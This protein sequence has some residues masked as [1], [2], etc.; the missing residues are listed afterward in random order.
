[1]KLRYIFILV[2][3]LVV[4]SGCKDDD[5]NNELTVSSSSYAVA[6]NQVAVR[7]QINSD[8]P[9]SVSSDA[10]WCVPDRDQGNGSETLTVMLELNTM[11]A[12]RSA[13]LTISNAFSSQKVQ[14]TQSGEEHYKL[15]VIFHVLY[16]DINDPNQYVRK[17]WL[18]KILTLCNQLYANQFEDRNEDKN[19]VDMN[20]EF[21]LA[22]T[23]PNGRTLEEPGANRIF[24]PTSTIDCDIFMNTEDPLHASLLWD[25]N[26][27][28][29]IFLYTFTNPGVAGIAHIP[30]TFSANPL[31]GLYSGDVYYTSQPAYPHCV[32]IN[33]VDIYV[34]EHPNNDVSVTL[35]HELGHYL[36]LFHAFGQ[37]RIKNDQYIDWKDDTDY[38][39]DTPNYDRGAYDQWLDEYFASIPPGESGSFYDVIKRTS[40]TGATFNSTNIMD[41]YYT[42]S[43]EF[44][45]DQRKRVRHVLN[46]SPL[47]PGAKYHR[48][49][50]RNITDMKKP[51]IRAI[52]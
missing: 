49:Q 52:Q 6:Y 20:V 47:I 46:Y 34:L 26:Q 33:N 28:I 24:W 10:V 39:D 19:S 45:P 3:L 37:S 17:D 9:W 31:N 5:S 50:S 32:S 51:P 38:C 12:E 21:I 44:T 35:A 8:L 40:I 29:N 7:I 1:M 4:I 2:L 25:L 18:P 22:T 13:T 42:W 48:P 43:D 23:D 14:V 30:Y 16:N 27:Y 41:Y 15:P 36:G 11:T